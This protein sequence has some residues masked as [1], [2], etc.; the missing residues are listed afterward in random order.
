[1][2][3]KLLYLIT[4]V[5]IIA[6]TLLTLRQQSIE[7]TYQIVLRHRQITQTRS[8]LWQLQAVMAPRLA[9]EA[10]VQSAVRSRLALEPMASNLHS[11]NAVAGGLALRS[12]P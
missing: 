4:A 7:A 1:M 5:F 10:L 3:A 11:R 12:S 8:A 9:P 6:A 2:F